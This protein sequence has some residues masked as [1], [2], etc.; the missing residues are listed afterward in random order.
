MGKIMMKAGDRVRHS[1]TG[2][3]G[4]IIGIGDINGRELAW[5]KWI[6]INGVE[7]QTVFPTGELIIDG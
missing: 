5:I 7:Q 1:E 2:I 4:D 3:G 6:D